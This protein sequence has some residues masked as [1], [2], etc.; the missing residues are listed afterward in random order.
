MKKGSRTDE[1]GVGPLAHKSCEGRIDLA[2]GAGVEDLDLQSD[3]ASSRFHVS[4][5]GL[6]IAGSVGLTSTATRVAAGTS[7][8]RSSSRFAANS[9]SEKIDPCQVAARPGE[10]GDKTKPDRVFGDGE[11]DGDRRGCRL[12]RQRRSGASGRDDHGDLS[13]N[14]IGRQL[15]QPI[16]LILGPAVYDR[17]VLALDIAGLLQALAKSA[18]TVRDH[19]RRLAVE[20]PDHRHRRLLRPRRQRPRRRRAAE[21]RDELAASSFDHL[22]GAGEQSRRHVEAERL[23]GLE[24]D[25]QLDLR[26]LL[27]RQIGWL[28][29]LEDAAS[30]DPGQPV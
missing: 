23:G 18:Q 2:A 13:A 26:G 29:A 7:S 19:V 14:Q 3:G 25:D 27:H 8:R 30:I 11:D 15:R 24:I 6:G 12:G 4:Q 20:E 28:L 10:A 21:Q 17:H 5:R 22:V 16:D 9:A 1:E